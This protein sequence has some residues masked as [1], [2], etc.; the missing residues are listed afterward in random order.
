MAH[1]VLS[2]LLLVWRISRPKARQP[3]ASA[4]RVPALTAKHQRQPVLLHGRPV[5]L[6]SVE[7]VEPALELAHHG[8]AGHQTSRHAEDEGA[9]PVLSAGR[10][11]LDDGAG[12]DLARRSGHGPPDRGHHHGA[13]RALVEQAGQPDQ[14]DHALNGHEGRHEGDRAGVAEAVGHPHP[15][16]RVLEEPAFP[17]PRQRRPGVVARQV[18]GL[19]H[20]AGGAHCRPA[21]ATHTVMAPASTAACR[22]FVAFRAPPSSS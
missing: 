15:H 2:A 14:A 21:S 12:E 4:T 13:D 5:P 22:R 8:G 9:V 7:P 10:V 17:D 16:E 3:K 20:Q 6:D 18:E 11:G 1:A 19:G